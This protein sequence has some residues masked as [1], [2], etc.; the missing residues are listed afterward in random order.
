MWVYDLQTLAFVA[1]NDAAVERYGFSTDEFL[2]MTIKQIRPP[3][4]IPRLEQDLRAETEVPGRPGR[5]GPWR[6]RTKSGELM[7]VEIASR[8]LTFEGRPARLVVVFDVTSA[9][10]AMEELKKT[11]IRTQ[12]IVATALDC[13]VSMDARGTIVEFNPAAEHTFRIA[14][15]EAVGRHL[16]DLIIPA[17]MRPQHEAGFAH[18]LAT[19]EQQILGRLL[20]LP[21]LRADGTEFPAEVTITLDTTS[22][23]PHFTGFIRDVTERKEAERIG[24]E[25]VAVQ[26]TLWNETQEMNAK[27]ERRVAER[28]AELEA[29]NAEL[30]SF[31]YSVSHDLR[32]PLRAMDG[33]A[34]LLA[35]DLPEE[36]GPEGARYIGIIRASARRMGE[37]VDDLLT[38]SRLGRA[39]L[40][41]QEV[42]AR[43]L[44]EEVLEDMRPVGAEAAVTIGELPHCD[45]DPTLLRVVFANLLSNAFKYSGKRARPEVRI[46]SGLRDGLPCYF[47]ADNGVGF[48]MRYA[49]KLF[50][51]FQRLHRI[52]EYEG[53]GVGL[54]TVQR[55]VHRHGGR[56]W[57]DAAVDDGATFSFS[58]QGGADGSSAG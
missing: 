57:A 31:S 19:G 29:S 36:M 40:R 58:L 50:G 18:F 24:K 22:G 53:T 44:V 45:A 13:I 26:Q 7:D 12:S 21:A 56:V 4:E 38:F 39:P 35:E 37:L 54:A 34:R 46:G 30:E 47:V 2:S 55:I 6:H 28:T 8:S 15:D 23:E 48:D 33:F 51:V 32:A 11:R 5:S 52:E 27:L 9:L 3:E 14:R 49:N 25:L 17:S 20:E 41:R 10:A 42:D 1:V 16:A 43:A